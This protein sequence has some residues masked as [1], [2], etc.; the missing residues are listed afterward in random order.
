MLGQSTKFNSLVLVSWRVSRACQSTNG[1]AIMRNLLVF[2]SMGPHGG[3]RYP[4]F[5]CT[6]DA[7]MAVWRLKF[8]TKGEVRRVRT[9]RYPC[10]SVAALIAFRQMRHGTTDFLCP[11][12]AISPLALKV[13]AG[14]VASA[15]MLWGV[16]RIKL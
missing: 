1:A 5:L 8:K 10:R 15:C 4:S 6:P 13:N 14:L 7:H 2:S 3:S 16:F 12:R 11:T 9:L